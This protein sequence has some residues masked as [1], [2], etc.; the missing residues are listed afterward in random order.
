MSGPL[1]GLLV[2]DLTQMLAGPFATMVLADLGA[3]VIKVEAAAGDAS[4]A[5][6]P[7]FADDE[8]PAFGGY[9]ASVNR[10]KRSVVIDLKTPAGVAVLKR[11]ATHAD[12]LVENFRVGVTERLGI[13]YE[14][15][16]EVNPRLVYASLSGFGDPRT[17]RSPYVD[18]PAFDITAQAMG[19]LMG[20]TGPDPDHPLKCGPG[21][22]DTVPGLFLAIG[23]LAAVREAERTQVGRFVDVAMYD[24]ILALS[25]RLVHQHSFTGAVPHPEGNGNP[26]LC[27]FDGFPA[28]DGWVTIAAPADPLWRALATLIG[29][30]ELGSDPGFATLAARVQRRQEVSAILT[31]WTSTRTK[32]EIVGLLAD[33]VPCAPVNDAADIFADPHVAA[34]NML[35]EVPHPGTTHTA[36]ICG[37]PVKLAGAAPHTPRR[38]P[39]LGEDTGT[40]LVELGF[41]RD[42]VE[43]LVAAGTVSR[44]AP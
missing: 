13:G 28:K 24:A 2:L 26:L 44:P 27:P 4:R 16:A 15:M 43:D 34:R 7:H 21:V 42:E 22:G 8:D 40:V 18:R 35:L 12:V 6:G 9:F 19:G 39:L 30:P 32:A 31:A 25:E 20:I 14:V 33:T 10:G 11:M 17:G 38:A 29:R 3:D 36:T 1:G 37:T 5:V 23:I 41:G